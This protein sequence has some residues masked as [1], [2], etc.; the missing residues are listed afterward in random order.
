[1]PRTTLAAACAVAML[2]LSLAAQQIVYV[3]R[4]ATGTADGT[5]WANAFPDLQQALALPGANLEIWVAAGAYRPHANDPLV[6]FQLRSG[7]ALYGGF[8][9]GE[10]ARWQRD[11]IAHVTTLTGDLA[12]DDLVGSGLLWYQGTVNFTENSE[13]VVEAAANV[14]ATAVLDGFEIGH[15]NAFDTTSTP[16]RVSGAG[17]FAN[18]SPTIANCTFTH[19]LSYWGGGAMV[20]A[21][22]APTVRGCRFV[23]NFASDGWGGAVYLS[24]TAP[25]DIGDCD[26]VANT[27]RAYIGGTGGGL[28]LDY[29]SSVTLHGCTFRGN[30]ARIS[31]GGPIGLAVGGGLFSGANSL[32]VDRC[33]FEDNASNSGGGVCCYRGATVTNSVFD[34]NIAV[35]YNGIG[36]S[37]GGLH[38]ST[39]LGT[40]PFNIRNCTFV[41]GTATND[42]GG[43]FLQN[44][45]GQVTRCVFWH[46]SD[47][48]GQIGRSQ[49][50]GG[51]PRYSCVQNLWIGVVGEDPPD[52]AN[53]PGSIDLLPQ[54]VSLLGANGQ[55]GGGDDDLHLLATSPC[56]DAVP[57]NQTMTGQ[58][59]DGLPRRIDGNADFTAQLDMGA[60]EFGYGRLAA[61][62]APAA[63]G[64]D[65]T[66]AVSGTTGLPVVLAIGA[67]GAELAF[68]PFGALFFDP[69]TPLATFFLGVI[70]VTTVANTMPSG[71]LVQL[72]ALVLDFGGAATLTNPV[73]V[74]L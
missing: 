49:C 31:F 29:G 22:G 60:F 21:G 64:V 23:E 28:Y 30:E 45:T 73:T 19:N 26:F 55:P 50:R 69:A 5:S 4:T 71:S 51:N 8:T 33:T 40:I 38:A 43:A 2:P 13:H 61:T 32:T 53:Y 18:G 1:M 11:P 7:V 15:G 27:S 63:N 20:I 37:G 62:A 56:I 25:I 46:N 44:T 16:Q 9:G 14:D 57:T 34:H 48:D 67:P 47:T 35:G 68:P 41:H 39:S 42:G 36:G 17:L 72:Q 58:D 3:D 54:F 10:T 70:P 59:R 12:A 66:I 74:R 6:A 24:S 65:V 52:P